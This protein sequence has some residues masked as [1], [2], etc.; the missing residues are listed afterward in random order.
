MYRVYTLEDPIDGLP[1]Y[2][3]YTGKSLPKRLSDHVCKANAADPESMNHRINWTRSVLKTGRRPVI[4][5]LEEYQEKN[6][7]TTS[8][9]FYIAVLRLMGFD[10]VN[11]SRG[12]EW[13]SAGAKR[14]QAT[15]DKISKAKLGKKLSPETCA[16]MSASHMGK[17]PINMEKYYREVRQYS[18]EGEY[19]ATFASLAE[20]GKQTGIAH[21]TIGQVARKLPLNKTGGGFIWRYPDDDEYGSSL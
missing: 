20:A 7:A 5:L 8:E 10:L 14:S 13:S 2:V 11:H 6:L 18:K 1:R 19:I 4:R 12:G 16:R 21:Q 17:P 9:R 3:G 15:K